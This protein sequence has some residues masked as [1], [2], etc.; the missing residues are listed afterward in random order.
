MKSRGTS[1][2]VSN[3]KFVGFFFQMDGKVDGLHLYMGQQCGSWMI[4]MAVVTHFAHASRN[5]TVS[6]ALL[7]ARSL[8]SIL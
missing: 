7:L 2:S 1:S 5:P 6:T 4:M 8:V 3:E